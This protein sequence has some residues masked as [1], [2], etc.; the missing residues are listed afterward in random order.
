M[1][2]EIAWLYFI[3]VSMLMKSNVIISPVCLLHCN[4]CPWCLRNKVRPQ[5]M[6]SWLLL[7]FHSARSILT[8]T[9]L[10]HTEFL[11]FSQQITVSPYSLLN[12]AL[13]GDLPVNPS[14]SE[15]LQEMPSSCIEI[16]CFVSHIMKNEDWHLASMCLCLDFS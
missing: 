5:M 4:V 13:D 12:P 16:M 6:V 10:I 9:A 2:K 14:T 8:L 15:G 1:Q 7:L 11:F 3:S